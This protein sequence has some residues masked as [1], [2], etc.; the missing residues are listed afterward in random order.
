MK[1]VDFGQ[2]EENAGQVVKES[3]P[4]ADGEEVT[5]TW[6]TPDKVADNSNLAIT[7]PQQNGDAVMHA[8]FLGTVKVAI[9]S[10]TYQ[11]GDK[12]SKPNTP[13][14]A[15]VR[16]EGATQGILFKLTIKSRD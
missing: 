1:T 15:T 6:I 5:A 11:F 2:Y 14:S 16:M 8:D 3:G 10:L 13:Y 7:Q 4:L 12:A 9:P